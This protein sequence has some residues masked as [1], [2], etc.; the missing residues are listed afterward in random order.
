VVLP[1]LFQQASWDD[2]A[3]FSYHK[4]I[5]WIPFL[6][7]CC[8]KLGIEKSLQASA[9]QPQYT[10]SVMASVTSRLFGQEKVPEKWRSDLLNNSSDC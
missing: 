4:L 1:T 2:K 9:T 5:Q 7:L 8:S 6:N 10:T 3:I